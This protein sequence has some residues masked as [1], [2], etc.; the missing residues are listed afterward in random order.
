MKKARILAV[1]MTFVL[2]FA[3]GCNKPASQTSNS[4]PPKAE[5]LPTFEELFAFNIS[6]YS[7]AI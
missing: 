7:A 6:L 3:L 4:E 5:E 1:L 2:A